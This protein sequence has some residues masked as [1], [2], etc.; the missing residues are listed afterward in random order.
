MGRVKWAAAPDPSLLLTGGCQEGPGGAAGRRRPREK[1]CHPSVRW[2]ERRCQP[3]EWRKTRCG[4]VELSYPTGCRGYH[5]S[6]A[7]AGRRGRGAGQGGLPGGKPLRTA[8]LAFVGDIS[9]V[10]SGHHRN[11]RRRRAA[12]L[13]RPGHRRKL[14]KSVVEP[15]ARLGT[16]LNAS[17]DDSRFRGGTGRAHVCRRSNWFFLLANNHALDQG[18]QG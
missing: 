1:V 12:G 3:I 6:F 15:L 2:P 11:R 17:R 9:A 13:S 4:R 7:L 14:R 5:A 18:V 16:A 10:A 8:R